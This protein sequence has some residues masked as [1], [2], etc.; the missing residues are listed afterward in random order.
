MNR[1]DKANTVISIFVLF[2]LVTVLVCL[3]LEWCGLLS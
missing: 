2:F 1:M 3:G